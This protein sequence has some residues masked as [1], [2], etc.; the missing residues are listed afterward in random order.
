M[1]GQASPTAGVASLSAQPL[2]VAPPPTGFSAD[3]AAQQQEANPYAQIGNALKS[4]AGGQQK[5]GQQKAGGMAGG[6][7]PGGRP[8]S[9]QQA[10]QMFTPEKF[11]GMLRNAGVRGQVRGS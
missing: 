6:E 4:I 10:R 2:A 8:I 7:A 1:P 5:Q 11:Y 9:L 3:P